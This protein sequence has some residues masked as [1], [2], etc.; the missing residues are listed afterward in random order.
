MPR[1]P[2]VG[3]TRK[4]G[5]PARLNLKTECRKALGFSDRTR[6]V[7]RIFHSLF[8]PPI[9]LDPHF[10]R[11]SMVIPRLCEKMRGFARVFALIFCLLLNLFVNC[12]RAAG[13]GNTC[14]AKCFARFAWTAMPLDW[15]EFARRR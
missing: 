2:G 14:L 3:V 5:A 8:M 11:A 1:C 13:W 9:P 7:F 6:M 4:S 15:M 12:D 10:Q